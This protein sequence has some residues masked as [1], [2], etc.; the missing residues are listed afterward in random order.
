MAR[1]GDTI[2]HPL[3]G[4]RIIFL[5]T[6]ADTNGEL[7]QLEVLFQPGGGPPAEH[8]HH[9]Q[10]ESFRVLSGTTRFRVNGEERTAQAGESVLVPKGTRHVWWN[11]GTDVAR[12]IVEFRPALKTDE[13]FESFWGLAQDGLVN[14]R[15]MPTPLRMA[16]IL[17]HYLD[18]LHLARIPRWVQR[19]VFRPLALIGRLK[20]YRA[21]YPYPYESAHYAVDESVG[22]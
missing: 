9:C 6:G 1:A 8:V 21:Q 13:F 11:S 22:A 3:T 5:K 16:V 4:E 7:L 10:D 12:T 2:E 15:G 14:A 17:D 20:G 19:A 18:E